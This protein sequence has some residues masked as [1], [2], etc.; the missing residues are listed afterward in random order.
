[1]IDVSISYE[2]MIGSKSL[3]DFGKKK[4]SEEEE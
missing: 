1:V 2:A 4:K 3:L